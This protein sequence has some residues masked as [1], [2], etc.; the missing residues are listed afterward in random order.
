MKKLW[1]A[2]CLF[3][4]LGI[5]AG[6]QNCGGNFESLQNLELNSH[7]SLDIDRSFVSVADV[8]EPL[9]LKF[10]FNNPGDMQNW[11]T[12]KGLSDG[13]VKTSSEGTGILW[14][15]VN[16]NDPQLINESVDINADDVRVIKIRVSRA[17]TPDRTLRFFWANEGQESFT[18]QQSVSIQLS[19]EDAYREYELPVDKSPLWFGRIR[20]IRIDPGETLGASAQAPS[21]IGIDYIRFF[22]PRGRFQGDILTVDSPSVDP[23]SV[24]SM[25]RQLDNFPLKAAPPARRVS[26]Y[27][28]SERLDRLK[29]KLTNSAAPV[30]LKYLNEANLQPES[31]S[32]A[33]LL[34]TV[35]SPAVPRIPRGIAFETNV[36]AEDNVA[37]NDPLWRRIEYVRDNNS[38]E[39]LAA[40]HLIS[41]AREVRRALVD[42]RADA[43][44]KASKREVAPPFF[45]KLEHSNR[46]RDF[47]VF[48]H[49]ARQNQ[50]TL[51]RDLEDLLLAVTSLRNRDGSYVAIV[52]NPQVDARDVGMEK[53]TP[54]AVYVQAYDLY[55]LGLERKLFT[56]N[57]DRHGRILH[58]ITQVTANALRVHDRWVQGDARESDPNEQIGWSRSGNNHQSYHNNAIYVGAA[59]LRAN[60]RRDLSYALKTYAVSSNANRIGGPRMPT[61]KES[62][63]PRG[64]IG[65]QK[66]AIMKQSPDWGGEQ[67]SPDA[68]TSFVRSSDPN[69]SFENGEIWD[70]YRNNQVEGGRNPT[71]RVARGLDYAFVNLGGLAMLAEAA[72]MQ[73]DLLKRADK[74]YVTFF[75]FDD[76]GVGL[77]DS[78]KFYLP[79]LVHFN[80]VG[81]GELLYT[82]QNQPLAK[83]TTSETI[84]RFRRRNPLPLEHAD[85]DA[86]GL[87][88]AYDMYYCRNVANASNPEYKAICKM[89]CKP[90]SADYNSLYPKGGAT[91]ASCRVVAQ[92][93]YTFDLFWMQVAPL[94]ERYQMQSKELCKKVAAA[95]TET[96]RRDLAVAKEAGGTT[97]SPF[98]AALFDIKPNCGKFQ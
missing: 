1:V 4:C 30:V 88:G 36:D 23:M 8:G 79:F 5:I 54:F 80:P 63:R 13:R 82:Q 92:R 48:A 91:E 50:S 90:Q 60:N 51:F 70:R 22:Y 87:R 67:K 37:T 55:T 11:H 26:V 59:A 62:L 98:M 84:N 40:T 66:L 47:A 78:L 73:G 15:Q 41:S 75:E 43:A 97:G 2:A 21:A 18:A 10:E 44:A 39:A 12:R 16:G 31:V 69:R 3:A 57:D 53:W 9:T 7:P 27:L 32:V 83:L 74:T 6:Y 29:E 76:L 24:A 17:P 49:L 38:S 56:T 20:K 72:T 25:L 86:I 65:M 71:R 61:I 19:T 58:F 96:K 52:G 45:I 34:D 77:R 85:F 35:S 64:Y 42:S 28:Q 81:G 46:I 14:A 33:Q 94:A 93:T 89:S 68:Q 95:Y